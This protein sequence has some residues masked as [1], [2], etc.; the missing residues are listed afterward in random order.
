MSIKRAIHNALNDIKIDLADEFDQNFERKG[1][2]ND[3]W[4]PVKR[5]PGTGSLM[6]RTGALRRSLTAELIGDNIV[7]S[8]SLPYADLH[9]RG[10]EVNM[11]VPVT[12]KMRKWAW[13]MYYQTDNDKYKGMALT[14]KS[15]FTAKFTM[16][17]RQFIGHAPQVD[18]IV[19]MNVNRNIKEYFNN[20]FS[21]QFKRR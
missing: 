13:A 19:E 8:S 6:L 4:D 3:S 1:F 7:F 9:N 5:D 18:E 15:H 10:G 12:T 16:P 17:K 2:F 21:Q 14:K 11:K 20:Y